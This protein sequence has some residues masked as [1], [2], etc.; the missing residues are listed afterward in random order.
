MPLFHG[1][2]Q[3][4]FPALIFGPVFIIVYKGGPPW[5]LE[6]CLCAYIALLSSR[7]ADPFSLLGRRILFPRFLIPSV[8][9]NSL[10]WTAERVTMAERATWTRAAAARGRER[11]M[12]RVILG[13]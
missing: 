3:S 11:A 7:H 9:D 1:S 4:S 5:S 8:H 12:K 2:V 6:C 10:L 13:C